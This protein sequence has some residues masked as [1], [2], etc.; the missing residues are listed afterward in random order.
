VYFIIRKKYNN[1]LKKTSFIQSMSLKGNAYDNAILEIFFGTLKCE[2]IYVQ[3][4]RSL[5]DLIKTI[6][7]K[8]TGITA[9]ESN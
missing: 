4:I 5:S 9:K 7:F 2:A 1:Y 6:I 8:F 3:K